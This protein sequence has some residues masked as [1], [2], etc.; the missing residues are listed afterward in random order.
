MD[1][2]KRV[3]EIHHLSASK[4]TKIRLLN[5]LIVDCL[6][7]M[8][9]QEQNMHPEIEHNLA[10]GYRVAKNYLRKLDPLH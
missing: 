10:E 1:M 5:D 9:A 8:E 4:K 3:S 7:E 6:N 2:R